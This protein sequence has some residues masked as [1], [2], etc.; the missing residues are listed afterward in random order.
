MKLILVRHGETQEGVF[1]EHK[2]HNGKRYDLYR[3]ALYRRDFPK[4][5]QSVIEACKKFT[6]HTVVY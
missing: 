3:F 2:L 5:Y 6:P 1:R 4:I